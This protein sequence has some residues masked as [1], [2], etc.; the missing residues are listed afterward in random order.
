V[1]LS[2]HPG[3]T[4]PLSLTVADGATGKYPQAEVYA[5]DG[6][7]L[8]TYDLTHRGNGLYTNNLQTMPTSHEFVTAVYVV[9]NDAGHTVESTTHLRASDIFAPDPTV[10]GTD[11]VDGTIDVMEA[12]KRGNA[13]AAGKIVRTA[14][15]YAYK[16][17][18][19]VT[20]VYAFDD[21][22]T[23]RTPA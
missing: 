5:D 7:L 12:L 17:E 1:S 18:D 2:I 15:H 23:E 19:G 9:Y 8:G 14:A 22:D 21:N 4:M 20:T 3:A 16:A 10:R 11:V 13:N 6:T